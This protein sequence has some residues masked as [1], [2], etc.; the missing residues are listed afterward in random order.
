MAADSP[1]KVASSSAE[2]LVFSC[3]SDSALAVEGYS[4]REGT[5]SLSAAVLHVQVHC[6]E[7]YHPFGDHLEDGPRSISPVEVCA[8]LWVLAALGAMASS[9]LLVSRL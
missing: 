3:T 7:I 1:L 5:L 9:M 2:L 8:P 6:Q 4:W